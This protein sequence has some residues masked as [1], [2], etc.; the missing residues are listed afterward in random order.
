MPVAAVLSLAGGGEWE[1]LLQAEIQWSY[2]GQKASLR[3]ES[4]NAGLLSRIKEVSPE[5]NNRKEARMETSHHPLRTAVKPHAA[6]GGLWD[7]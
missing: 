5:D 1:K 3:V 6:E 4:G 2:S 7:L